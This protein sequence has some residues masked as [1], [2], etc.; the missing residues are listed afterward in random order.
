MGDLKAEI[1][2]MPWGAMIVFAFGYAGY[3]IANIGA[4]DHHKTIEVILSTLFFGYCALFAYEYWTIALDGTD[5]IG[6]IIAFLVA[7][8]LGA[9]WGVWVRGW[10]EALIRFLGVS[11]A[12]NLPS[13]WNALLVEKTIGTQLTVQ[14]KD[15]SWIKCESL[16]DFANK[17]NG[18]CVFGAK[19][20]L[21]MYATHRQLATDDDFQKTDSA[22]DAV[23]GNE[24]TY[25][26]A[27]QITR[28][29]Y[30]RTKKNK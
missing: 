12:D 3:G 30:R 19:G 2:K 24:I 6:S 20:D 26:P 29:D 5:W 8:V 4:R 25:I 28:V 11:Y 13:A 7:V 18:P 14:L 17:P 22:V 16:S 9:V 23:W 10:V 15:G 21:L 27:D 1:L